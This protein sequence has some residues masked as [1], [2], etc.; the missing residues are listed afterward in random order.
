ML[1]TFEE[2]QEGQVLGRSSRMGG[3]KGL[4]LLGRR[5][6]PLEFGGGERR[7]EAGVGGAFNRS[8]RRRQT[9]SSVRKRVSGQGCC[10]PCFSRG[11]S[12]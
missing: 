6:E 2:H 4:F 5:V 7:R 10:L 3:D 9:S 12:V 8:H 1:V 11:N